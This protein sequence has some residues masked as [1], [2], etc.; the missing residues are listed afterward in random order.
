[1][2]AAAYIGGF[3]PVQPGKAGSDL[4]FTHR[5]PPGKGR[6]VTPAR[7]FQNHFAACPLI[8]IIRGVTPEEVVAI[9]QA[10]YDG[11]IRIIEVPLNSPDPLDSIHRLAASLG[12]KA[13][14]GAGTVLKVDQVDQVK[15]A[16]GRLIVSPNANPA[17]IA[18]AVACDLVSCPGVFTPT[19]AFAAIEAGAHALK[20]FP[21]EAGSPAV[22]RAQR[23]VLPRNIPILAVGGVTLDTVS[24]WLAAGADGAGVSS[25]LYKPGQ[26]PAETRGKAAAF[27]AAVRP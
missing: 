21:A 22:I 1:L 25:A 13:L 8:A 4:S 11:G 2:R 10:L 20:F 9:G 14:V 15:N 17:V 7:D 18:R 6:G 12:D 3:R 26:S 16:G 27:A 5:A 24:A 19:E 23:T